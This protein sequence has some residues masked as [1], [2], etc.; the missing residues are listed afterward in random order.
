MKRLLALLLALLLC[1]SAGMAESMI[2]LGQTQPEIALNEPCRIE[3]AYT[4]TAAEPVFSPAETNGKQQMSL[5]LYFKNLSREN[6][7][8]ASITSMLVIFQDR[9]ELPLEFQKYTHVRTPV[10]AAAPFLLEPLIEING[11]WAAEVPDAI[12]NAGDGQLE[13]EITIGSDI[14]TVLLR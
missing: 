2:I 13:L 6:I 1:A 12:A 3:G 10:D 9:F 5:S 11:T 4:F 8:L 7:E 14:Y